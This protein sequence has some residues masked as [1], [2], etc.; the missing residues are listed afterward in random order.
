MGWEEKKKTSN[1]Y[2]NLGARIYDIRYS[3]EQE[4][5]YRLLIEK[6]KPKIDD[7]ILDVGCGTGLLIKK[8]DS[9]AIG[10]DLSKELLKT[11][12][13]RTHKNQN[14][15]LLYADAEWIPI[16][17][18][19]FQMIISVTLLQN[20][21]NPESVLKE[22]F[23]LGRSKSHIAITYLKKAITTKRFKKIVEKNGFIL[24]SILN[25]SKSKDLIAFAQKPVSE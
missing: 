24:V 15:S 7:I 4:I 1:F 5:K 14:T 12:Y 22:I 13:N 8:F 16:R 9:Y 18:N 21:P 10:L 11:A 19:I 23:R 3:E 2:D 6:Y 20:M 17:D 25:S